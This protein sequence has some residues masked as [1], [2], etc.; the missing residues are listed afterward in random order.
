MIIPSIFSDLYKN[1][2]T[3]KSVVSYQANPPIFK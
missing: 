3:E 2:K 1:N